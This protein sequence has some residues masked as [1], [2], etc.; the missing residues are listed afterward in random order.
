MPFQHT[1]LPLIVSLWVD[2]NRFAMMSS[3]HSLEIFTK[4]SDVVQK[5]VNTKREHE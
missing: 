1:K 3:Y 2:N 5:K 4:G